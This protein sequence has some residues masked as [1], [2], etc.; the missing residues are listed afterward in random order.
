MKWSLLALCA[1][2]LVVPALAEEPSPTPSATPDSVVVGGYTAPETPTPVP[3]PEPP[4]LRDDPMLQNVVEIAHRIDILAENERFMNY[5]T[6]GVISREQIETLTYGDHTRPARAFHLKGQALIDAL[7]AGIAQTLDF[8][9]P[10]LQWD[11]VG[12]LPEILWG[13]QE[14]M[15]LAVLALL[16]RYKVFALPGAEGCGLFVLLYEEGAPVIVTWAAQQDCVCASAFFMPDDTLAA[17]SAPE[18]ISAWFASAG[19]P[20]VPFEEVPLT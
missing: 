11:L 18:D 13:R 15:D 16:A 14:E 19:M 7:H 10:E 9:R 20:D 2:L 3:T 5:F 1:L 8:S 17:A 6:Y 12:E 4:P